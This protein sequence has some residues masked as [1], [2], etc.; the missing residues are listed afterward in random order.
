[1]IRN[2]RDETFEQ[3]DLDSSNSGIARIQTL[4][5]ARPKST[6]IE[7]MGPFKGTHSNVCL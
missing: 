1:M 4:I 7:K 3:N 5:S 2:G 6:Y